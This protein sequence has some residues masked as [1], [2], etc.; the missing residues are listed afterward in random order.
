MTP[1]TPLPLQ[2]PIDLGHAL[3]I[4]LTLPPS[5]IS[6][7]WASV[8]GGEIRE[9]DHGP[10]VFFDDS[11]ATMDV[12]LPGQAQATRFILVKLH[13]HHESE[14]RINGVRSPLELHIVH[15]TTE[16]NPFSWGQTREIY[17]V[18]GVLVEGGGQKGSSDDALRKLIGRIK[19]A[20]LAEPSDTKR[21]TR[22]EEPLN[23]ND[24]V[25][26]DPTTP[27]TN[28]PLWR[29]EGSLTS[30]T[31]EP[32][33]GYVSWVVLQP[34]L[35]VTDETLAEWNVLKHE[36]KASQPLDRRFVFYNPGEKAGG[37]V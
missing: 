6:I 26:F 9:G 20:G 16:P 29:Y 22:L 17:A 5:A 14:H 25:P 34:K 3:P 2:S 37:V 12:Q 30:K 31:H 11:T 28:Q 18:L 4:T 10:E 21:S 1:Y 8:I 32:N 19:E 23:P 7:A 36:A 15:K 13:F 24:L 35:R 27:L 33:T